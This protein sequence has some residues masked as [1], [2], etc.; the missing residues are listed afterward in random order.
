MK[1]QPCIVVQK[2][3]ILQVKAAGEARDSSSSDSFSSQHADETVDNA[4]IST[5][6]SDFVLVKNRHKSLRPRKRPSAARIAAQRAIKAQKCVKQKY[7]LK[8]SIPVTNRRVA[9]DQELGVES[10]TTIIYDV[11]EI[12]KVPPQA[13]VT[14]SMCSPISFFQQ[15]KTALWVGSSSLVH[16]L[17][18]SISV[19]SLS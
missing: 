11:P 19:S 7:T 6:S 18:H 17:F 12:Y 16:N 5:T 2:L 14:V 15:C 10:D 13:T 8:S 9:P 3:D 4:S 1:N